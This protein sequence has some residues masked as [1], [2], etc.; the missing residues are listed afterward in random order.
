MIFQKKDN[1]YMGQGGDILPF[2]R[3]ASLRDGHDGG[4][5]SVSIL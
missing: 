5:G 3:R 2:Y 1:G 4:T